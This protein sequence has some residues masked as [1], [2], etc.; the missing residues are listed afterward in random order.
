MLKQ[1]HL[2]MQMKFKKLILES[3]GDPMT[4]LTLS[5]SANYTRKVGLWFAISLSKS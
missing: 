2:M 3:Y 1:S 4:V 5:S